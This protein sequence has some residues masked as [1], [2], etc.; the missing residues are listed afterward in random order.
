MPTLIL[1]GERNGH[2]PP[3]WA[4]RL[5]TDIP[6]VNRVELLPGVGHLLMEE[7]PDRVAA[8]IGEFLTTTT[9]L[10]GGL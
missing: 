6:S 4:R 9:D 8:L 5:A 10:P 3:Q 7:Q 1:W 2:F